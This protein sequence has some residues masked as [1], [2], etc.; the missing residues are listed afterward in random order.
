MISLPIF[1]VYVYL[2]VLL[3]RRRA[4][5]H[6]THAGCRL[7]SVYATLCI[8]GQSR[9]IKATDRAAPRPKSSGRS[10]P[11]AAMSAAIPGA[12]IEVLLELLPLR[13]VFA[14]A[15]RSR[16]RKRCSTASTA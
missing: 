1:K 13:Q 12:I 15:Q 9:H 3:L 10:C 14:L 5:R 2:T 6:C 4:S 11:T 7:R 8:A 16:R